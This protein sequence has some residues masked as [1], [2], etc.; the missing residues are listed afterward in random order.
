MGRNIRHKH[1]LGFLPL[2]VHS[3]APQERLLYHQLRLYK[4]LYWTTGPS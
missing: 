4:R 2:K 3:A 1:R